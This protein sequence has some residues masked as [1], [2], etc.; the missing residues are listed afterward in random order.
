MIDTTACIPGRHILFVTLDSLRYDVAHQ[1]TATGRT[2][3]LSAILPSGQ[4]ERR[5][6]PG[7]FTYP[8]HQAFFAGFLPKPA[9]PTP[10]SRLWECR[11][12]VGKAIRPTTYVFD[13]PDIITGLA[14][15]G[16][17][18]VCIGG[19]SYFSRETPL[20][21]TLP[22]YFTEDHWE[23]A[24]ASAE[25]DSTRHQ[26]DRALS[27]LNDV[28]NRQPVMLFLNVSATHI[29]HH[30]YVTD[31]D[32]IDSTDSQAAAL[33]YADGQLGRLLDALPA[34]GAWLVVATADHGD[35]FGD[36]GFT[37]H[38]IAH[39]AVFTVPYAETLVG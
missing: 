9:L 31:S 8:A 38:G 29:P 22:D 27:L 36:D 1:T 14:D 25:P 2:P 34:F 21:S 3:C 13:A 33:A 26:V 4:W 20:G 6:T 30:H 35:T 19:V 16:Y 32:G 5:H 18:T 37:G 15:L 10:P 7:T 17:R 24:F 39:P 28:Q 12:P 11:P 23:P